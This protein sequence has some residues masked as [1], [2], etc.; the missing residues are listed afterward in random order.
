MSGDNNS[1]AKYRTAAAIGE[2]VLKQA[3]VVVVPGMSTAAV[4]RY[5][6]ELIEAHCKAVFRK[7]TSIERGVAVPT[8]VSV[9]RII[10]NHSPS[11]DDDYVLREGDVAKIEVNVHIDGFIAAVAFTSVATS[12]PEVPVTDRRADA[13]S[14]AYYGSEVVARMIRPGQG[15]RNVVKAL[16]LVASGFGCTVAGETFTSQIDQF[17]LSGKNTFANRFDPD[18][19]A[20]DLTFETGEVYTVDCTLSTGS[21]I[22]RESA[23]NSAIYQRD[24]N[25]QYSLRLRSARGLFSE[26]CKRYSVFPFLMRD[27]VG[28]DSSLKAGLGECVRSQLLVPF[29][30]TTDKEPGD[31]FVAQFKLTVMCHY[32]GPIRLTRAIA[33][34][35]NVQSA[36]TIP[37]E[38]EIGQ[39]LALDCQQAALPELPRMKLQIQTPVAATLAGTA[40]APA[41]MDI[42]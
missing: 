25:R 42:S 41:R 29:A 14:A 38:S 20:P 11:A 13:I 2:Q 9:N 34:P 37:A 5:V 40:T 22:A 8:T 15:A 27:A 23:H 24:V 36:T 26:V 39:I 35:S 6:D 19:P 32:E 33:V 3:A 7:E 4:C 28:N 17:V 12:S 16:A 1:D 10:Q 31:T 30:V 18:M 21:G